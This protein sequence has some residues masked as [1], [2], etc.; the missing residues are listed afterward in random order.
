VP[1]HDVQGEPEMSRGG[2]ERSALKHAGG[3]DAAPSGRPVLTMAHDV[4]VPGCQDTPGEEANPA[5]EGAW[6]RPRDTSEVDRCHPVPE[7]R[8]EEGAVIRE[9]VLSPD[10]DRLGVI[11]QGTA[12]EIDRIG[13]GVALGVFESDHGHTP[14]SRLLTKGT[15]LWYSSLMS[16]QQP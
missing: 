2:A 1:A 4:G 10:D 12:S 9:Q 7:N 14:V 16:E 13:K 6:G 8:L 15:D 3:G 5:A 11:T